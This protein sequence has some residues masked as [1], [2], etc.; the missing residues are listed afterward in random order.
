MA[1]RDL[2]VGLF[3]GILFGMYVGW[4]FGPDRPW[5]QVSFTAPAEAAA[6]GGRRATCPPC[7]ATVPPGT[8]VDAAAVIEAQDQQIRALSDLAFGRPMVWPDPDEP[9]RI[10]EELPAA[11]DSCGPEVKFLDVDC[12]EPPCLGIFE[13]DDRTATVSDFCPDIAPN[14]YTSAFIPCPEGR[15]RV[16]VVKLAGDG[17]YREGNESEDLDFG[18]NAARRFETRA[19]DALAAHACQ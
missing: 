4:A 3:G 11:L 16:H 12:S 5:R 8:S 19:W 14:G 15:R 10:E 18:R 7:A 9:A 17:S 13:V 1:T 2:A 6:L